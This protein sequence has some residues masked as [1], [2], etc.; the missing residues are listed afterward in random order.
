ML[1]K[2]PCWVKYDTCIRVT[3][4]DET[5]FNEEKKAKCFIIKNDLIQEVIYTGSGKP[6]EYKSYAEMLKLLSV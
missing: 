6:K 2:I 1:P 5:K 3:C 4:T